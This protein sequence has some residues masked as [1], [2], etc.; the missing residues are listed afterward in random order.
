M[1]RLAPHVVASQLHLCHSHFRLGG[2]VHAARA[3][4][5]SKETAAGTA[6]DRSSTAV[7]SDVAGWVVRASRR[8]QRRR[9]MCGSRRVP[10]VRRRTGSC[11]GS[12]SDTPRRSRTARCTCTT[13]L[14]RTQMRPVSLPRCCR[15]PGCP[16]PFGCNVVGSC[17]GYL[18]TMSQP[19]V[20]D[21]TKLHGRCGTA[22]R[23]AS[24]R[25]RRCRQASAWRRCHST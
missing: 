10:L 3:G 12:A 14:K 7:C 20:S 1:Q 8:S 6:A 24:G 13:H 11:C 19:T 25:R 22:F 16:P 4:W 15:V 23:R 18:S 2:G 9:S 21:P 5:A 17:T